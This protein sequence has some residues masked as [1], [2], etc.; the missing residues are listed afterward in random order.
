MGSRGI[1]LSG[2]HW[3][4][5]G[6][7]IRHAPDNGLKIEGSHNRVERCVFHHNGDSGLQIGLGKK[8][9]NDDGARAAHNAI[10]NCDSFRNFDARTK[11][12]NADGFACKLYPGAGN[13]F[14]G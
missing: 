10:V 11:G 4:I 9:E 6:L 2:D 3:V 1:L 5:E 8:S 7:E 13:S 14:A 12:E